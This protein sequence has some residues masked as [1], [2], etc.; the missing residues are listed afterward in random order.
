MHE[1]TQVAISSSCP[2]MLEL[3]APQLFLPLFSCQS[4]YAPFVAEKEL[5]QKQWVLG[6]SGSAKHGGSGVR[7]GSIYVS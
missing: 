6:G 1:A 7:F 3:E 2:K 4:R 5:G